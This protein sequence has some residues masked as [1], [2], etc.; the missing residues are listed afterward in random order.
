MMLVPPILYG[1]RAFSET[2]ARPDLSAATG[3]PSWAGKSKKVKGG[4]RQMKVAG[5]KRCPAL[6]CLFTFA[7][8]MLETLAGDEST[9]ESFA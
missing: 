1:M 7:R 6:L 8:R 2:S 5:L 4:R 3:V 9:V